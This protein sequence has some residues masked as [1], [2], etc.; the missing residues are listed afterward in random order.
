M[1]LFGRKNISEQ[2]IF[3]IEYLYIEIYTEN[4]KIYR[5]YLVGC[6]DTAELLPGRCMKTFTD[7]ISF[8][9]SI[10]IN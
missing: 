6:V 8:Y 9:E 1:K 3:D 7:I 4:I 5:K 2:K 10:L